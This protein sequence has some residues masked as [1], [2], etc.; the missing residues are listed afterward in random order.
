MDN[1][2][3]A[4]DMEE[5]VEAVTDSEESV[6][7]E[8]PKTGSGK[9]STSRFN[10]FWKFIYSDLLPMLIITLV[11]AVLINKLNY[12]EELFEKD[13]L[14]EGIIKL[15]ENDAD[16]RAV[17]FLYENRPM[18]KSN[19][20]F[21]FKHRRN[22][23]KPYN[24]PLSEVLE[25]IR[26][27]IY[28][29]DEKNNGQLVKLETVIDT[30][31]TTNPFDKLESG[32]KDLFEN[33]RVKLADDYN[34]VSSEV[35]KLSDELHNKN[36][37]IN[38][39]LS[40]SKTSLYISMLSAFFAVFLAG[41]QIFQNSRF[42]RFQIGQDNTKI[43]SSDEDGNRVTTTHYSDGRTIKKVYGKDGNVLSRSSTYGNSKITD[44]AAG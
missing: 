21:W 19:L 41:V 7:S 17:K 24:L 31:N 36:L 20:L 35:N 18:V 11:I 33:I 40:D 32:Q 10:K 26:T 44:A 15:I 14:K 25:E 38:E 30:Y 42:G 22:D 5:N 43:L 1:D 2:K 4:V 29:S 12:Q 28:L 3:T 6:P 23:Y 37:L 34:M 16:L 13:T 9:E 39:Y 8:G 27:Q